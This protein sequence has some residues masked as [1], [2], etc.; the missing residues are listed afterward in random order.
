VPA[1]VLVTELVE[2]RETFVVCYMIQILFVQ[3][4]VR[5]A[6][7]GHL[8]TICVGRQWSRGEATFL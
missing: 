3:S 8:E 7:S 4:L 5:Q 2:E 6:S 1:M